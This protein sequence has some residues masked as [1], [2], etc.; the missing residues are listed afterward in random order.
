MQQPARHQS[1]HVLRARAAGG[2]QCSDLQGSGACTCSELELQECSTTWR[3]NSPMH[4]PYYTHMHKVTAP[5][6][7]TYQGQHST[8]KVSSHEYSVMTEGNQRTAVDGSII[9]G[10]WME[11]GMHGA[12]TAG[13]MGG[14]VRCRHRKQGTNC[15]PILKG[16]PE[17]SRLRGG[18]H[19]RDPR[20]RQQP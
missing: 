17:G 11:W 20:P 1:T 18:T 4:T 12:Q 9:L 5:P 8:I 16:A 10:A 19:Q 3:N 6:A 7:L 13:F 15:F 2:R 14:R